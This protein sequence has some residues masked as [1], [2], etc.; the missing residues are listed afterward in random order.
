MP[1]DVDTLAVCERRRRDE[2]HQREER[3]CIAQQPTGEV[4]PQLVSVR[5]GCEPSHETGAS[6]HQLGG[7]NRSQVERASGMNCDLGRREQAGI[8][9][10]DALQLARDRGFDAEAHDLEAGGLRSPRRRGLPRPEMPDEMDPQTTVQRL[11][12]KTSRRCLALW[13]LRS[14]S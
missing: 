14:A 7:C 8:D 9:D 2:L 5:E 1:I 11:H 3:A 13:S 12:G 6:T 4:A 10:P